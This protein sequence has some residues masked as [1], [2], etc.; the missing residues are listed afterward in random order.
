[1]IVQVKFIFKAL[2]FIFVATFLQVAISAEIDGL[3]IT[4]VSKGSIYEKLNLKAGDIIKSVNGQTVRNQK[5]FSSFEKIIKSAD[6]IEIE[7]LRNGVT[8]KI[9]VKIK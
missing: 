1:M 5:D 7:F 4:S 8:Q 6:K 3:K 9:S 2:L